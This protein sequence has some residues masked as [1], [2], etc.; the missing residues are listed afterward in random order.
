LGV[1]NQEEREDKSADI[2]TGF[3]HS[4]P[5]AEGKRHCMTGQHARNKSETVSHRIRKGFKVI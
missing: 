2:T 4:P 5:A 1:C 3:S